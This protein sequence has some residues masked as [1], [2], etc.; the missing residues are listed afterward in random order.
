M[1]YIVYREKNRNQEPNSYLVSRESYLV[2]K[3]PGVLFVSRIAYRV[4]RE[5]GRRKKKI[6]SKHKVGVRFIEPVSG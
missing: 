6:I 2:K 5:K 4:L 1:S 3:K